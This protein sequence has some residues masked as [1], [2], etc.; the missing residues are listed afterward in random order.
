MRTMTPVSQTS[1]PSE[2]LAATRAARPCK[3]LLLAGLSLWAAAL[4]ACAPVLGPK[5]QL[6]KPDAYADAK[7]FAGPATD[8]PSERWWAMYGD[9][10]LD[11]LE[12]QALVGSPDLKAAEARL[13]DAT[14]S[15]EV[16]RAALLPRSAVKAAS[17]P[18]SR[19]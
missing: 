7:S 15:V 8:W 3:A 1:A 2:P 13:R 5:P 6:S 4:A 16:A 18:A 19:A 11:A 14:A 17:R 10:Q 12:D 9:P